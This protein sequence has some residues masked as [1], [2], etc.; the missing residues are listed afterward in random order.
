MPQPDR[1]PESSSPAKVV[2]LTH[3]RFGRRDW[4]FLWLRRIRIRRDMGRFKWPTI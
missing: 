1:T 2:R 4:R 3:T